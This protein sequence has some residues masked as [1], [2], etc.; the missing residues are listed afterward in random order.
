MKQNKN[1]SSLHF[2]Q[3]GRGWGRGKW[4]VLVAWAVRGM[5][6][7]AQLSTLEFF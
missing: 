7:P 4:G 6:E 5:N 2:P 3:F 1:D